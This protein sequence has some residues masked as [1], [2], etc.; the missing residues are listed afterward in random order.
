MNLFKKI[1]LLLFVIIVAEII[2]Y[3]FAKYI[4]DYFGKFIFQ[5]DAFG[6]FIR[7]FIHR[8]VQFI[9]VFILLKLMF[10]DKLSNLGFNFWNKGLSLKILGYVVI[11]WPIIVF[12]FFLFSMTYVNGFKSYIFNSYPPS[13]TQMAASLSRDILLL[14]AFAEEI[15][16]RTFVI[17]TLRR[18]WNGR[19]KVYNCSVSHATLLSVPIFMLAHVAISIFPFRVISYDPIQLCLTFFTGL[20]FAVS[21]EKTQSLFSPIIL[22]GYTNLII[23]LAGYLT[24]FSLN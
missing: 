5:T 17:L 9:L 23:T 20:L 15:L 21:F 18:Y 22:H 4:D 7:A 1:L 12:V 13:A 11:S 2:P 8:S 14:D 10:Q 3:G 19:I 16:Y 24:T 6:Y